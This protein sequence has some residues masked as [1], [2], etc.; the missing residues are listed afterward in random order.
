MAIRLRTVQ[1]KLVALCAAET[2]PCVG[3]LYLDDEIHYALTLKTMRESGIPDPDDEAR[4]ET[5]ILRDA[6][7]MLETWLA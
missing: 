1:G 2:D 5:Q 6:K 3:D 4:A 7:T